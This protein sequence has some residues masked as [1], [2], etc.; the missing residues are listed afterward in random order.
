MTAR[1]VLWLLAAFAWVWVT[2]QLVAGGV[3]GSRARLVVWVAL[4]VVML[5]AT[6]WQFNQRANRTKQ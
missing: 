5:V 1:F 3:T 2:A 4:S 6:L